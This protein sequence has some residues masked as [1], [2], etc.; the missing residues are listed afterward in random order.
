MQ[1][2]E[3]IMRRRP[4]GTHVV[5]PLLVAITP[6]LLGLGT[7]GGRDVIHPTMD[8]RATLVDRDGT[9]V[10]VS[11]L[12]I[13]G[14]VQLEGD[15]GRGSLRIPF[16]NIRSVELSTD[17]HDYSR[18]TVHLKTGETVALRVRN[19]LLIYGQTSVGLY[20]IRAR[21]LRSITLNPAETR[22]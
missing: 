21:D 11:R 9:K 17:S 20:Q 6:L 3:E 5:L 1:A 12:N 16:D 22:K 8:F 13:G 7:T 15:M 18:A 14:D 4:Y 2:P 10:E 19:S